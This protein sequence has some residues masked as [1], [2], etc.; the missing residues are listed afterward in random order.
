MNDAALH[1]YRPAQRAFDTVAL[2]VFAGLLLAEATRLVLAA[3]PWAALGWGLL[4]LPLA[5]L[6]ADGASGLLHLAL[7]NC[8]SV[9]TPVIGP[10]FIR[11]F[12]EHHVD[13]QAMACHGFVETNGASA[14]ACLPILGVAALLPLHGAVLQAL[15]AGLLALGLC[16][17]L[18]NECHR[19]AHAAPTATPAWARWA[20]RHRLILPPAHHQRH[21]TAP[22]DSHFCMANGWLNPVLN[23]V[24]RWRRRPGR[25]RA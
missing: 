5:W 13:P 17:V 15:H 23:T 1:R 6:L 12:R 19:W 9:K 18:I 22:F 21:H 14:L 2:L 11:P 7:D 16:A 4:A 25:G 3:G 20:Q 10:A 24:L 8:G